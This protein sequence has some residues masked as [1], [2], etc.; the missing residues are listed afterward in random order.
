MNARQ[1]ISSVT[2]LFFL[3]ALT[4]AIRSHAAFSEPAVAPPNGDAYA[5]LNTSGTGQTKVGGLVLNTGAATVGLSV[6]N[7]R[8]DIGTVPAGTTVTSAVGLGIWGGKQLRIVD[9]SEGAGKVLT[10]NANGLATWSRVMQAGIEKGDV[11]T[12]VVT[13]PVSMPDATY[14]VSVQYST[15]PSSNSTDC[16]TPMVV[17]SS[18]ATTGFTF[19]TGDDCSAIPYHWIVVDY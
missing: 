13:F 10:S 17:S 16:R 14:A 4:F 8:I 11:K 19:T 15:D 6:P 5:P 12:H 3:L 1:F 9:G 18:L 2:G 7:G